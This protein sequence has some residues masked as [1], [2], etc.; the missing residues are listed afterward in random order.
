MNILSLP[1]L[2]DLNEWSVMLD[3]IVMQTIGN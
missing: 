2:M 3:K 1:M